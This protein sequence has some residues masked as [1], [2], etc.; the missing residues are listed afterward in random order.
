MQF[1]FSKTLAKLA[2]CFL[3]AVSL[4][5]EA[6]AQSGH[7]WSVIGVS[8]NDTL[9]VRAGPGTQFPVI[10][11]LGYN[12]SGLRKVTCTPYTRQDRNYS[13]SLRSQLNQMTKWCLVKMSG[14]SYA[15]GWVNNRFLGQGGS[16]NSQTGLTHAQACA[17]NPSINADLGRRSAWRLKD[18]R[19]IQRVTQNMSPQWDANRTWWS[20]W[21]DAGR[22]LNAAPTKMDFVVDFCSCGNQPATYALTNVRVDDRLEVFMDTV[23]WTDI[24]P[25]FNPNTTGASNTNKTNMAAGQRQLMLRLHNDPGGAD[26]PTG[27]S[28]GGFLVAEKSYLGRCKN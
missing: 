21:R 4:T 17:Q 28:L 9:N 27:V 13:N 10:D 22:Y 11:R 26:N 25:N 16:S 15:A 1:D 8:S 6:V 24:G 3:I 5:P 12:Q 19:P 2:A 7:S 14:A 20:A 23:N 18:G